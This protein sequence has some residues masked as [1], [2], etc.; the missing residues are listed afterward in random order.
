MAK[1]GPEVWIGLLGEDLITATGA[2]KKTEL[3]VTRSQ[4][5]EAERC[6]FGHDV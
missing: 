5:K 3:S 1:A 6:T 4:R 2:R